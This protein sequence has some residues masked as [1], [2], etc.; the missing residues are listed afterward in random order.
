MNESPQ[1]SERTFLLNKLVVE[2]HINV[3]E[4]LSLGVVRRKEIAEIVRTLLLRD[5]TFPLRPETRAIYEG[6]RL[7]RKDSEIQIVW[8][9]AYPWD[10]FT[11]AEKRSV[12]FAET[13]AAIQTF[14]DS[15]WDSGID[16][17]PLH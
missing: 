6:P 1:V 4:R 14:I 15:A 2:G 7:I 8:E 12:A 9:R 16:G 17:I 5:G 13:D 3:A 10:P 11:V